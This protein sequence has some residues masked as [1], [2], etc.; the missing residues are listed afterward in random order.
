MRAFFGGRGRL[1]L[2]FLA[3]SGIV[4]ALLMFPAPPE[5]APATYGGRM[6]L[7]PDGLQTR[8]SPVTTPAPGVSY[9]TFTQG[10]PSDR[11]TVWVRRNGVET[12]GNKSIAEEFVTE[13]EA[14]GF[15]GTLATFF[16]PAS[17]DTPGTVIGYGVR[18]GSFPPENKAGVDRLAGRVREKGYGARVVYT[19]LD[20]LPSDGPWKVHVVRVAPTAAVSFRAVHGSDIATSET[21][22]RM[23][24]ASGA[25]A[26]VNGSEFDIRTSPGFS[27][28][29]G[30][31][32]G[33]YVKDGVLLGAANNGRSALLLQGTGARLRVTETT[34]TLQVTAPDGRVRAIDGV[35]R[36]PGRVAGCGGVGGDQLGPSGSKKP[37][38]KPWRNQLCLDANEI[39]MFR[40]EWGRSTPTPHTGVTDSVDVVL[41][42]EWVVKEVRS[43]AGGAIPA[44]SRVLQ[45]I[46]AGAEW[47]R[48]GAAVGASFKFGAT[49]R[50]ADGG[51]V[52]GPALSAVAGGGPAL[53]RGGEIF[54]N[55][56]ANGLTSLNG[57]PNMTLV[58]RHPRTMAGV[59]ESGEV[60]L[61]T[62]DG[63]A[64]DSSVGVTWTEAAAVM[65][66]LGATEAIGLGSGG[67]TTMVIDG[68]VANRPMDDWGRRSTER[69]VSNAIVVV[70][71][72]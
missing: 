10:A 41:T 52:A 14:D 40:P 62:V 58:Q 37:T 4:A 47:L 59:T 5:A 20:G 16:S 17:S 36:V 42:D 70:P 53:V 31:P 65:K 71:Q 23:A 6:P 30:V 29:E 68:D 7:G 28:F 8:A 27:G 51:V 55:V 67:D 2:L 39:V 46:G 69:K 63:R 22:H 11:W 56:A 18:V 1:V 44:G 25:V 3:A 24:A 61:V 45:G 48:T 34:S 50:D 57:E 32:Q 49:I 15:T 54:V 33:L 9:Q 72:L 13:L 60:L 66:W 35:N 43:P 64:V 21:V 19:A 38:L 12:F 26:A